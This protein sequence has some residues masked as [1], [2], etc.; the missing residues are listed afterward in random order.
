MF[1]AAVCSWIVSTSRLMNVSLPDVKLTFTCWVIPDER[2]LPVC[3]SAQPASGRKRPPPVHF[4][5]PQKAT[6]NLSPFVVT[7][8]PLCLA[9]FNEL[10]TVLCQQHNEDCPK[11]R[12][13]IPF[14]RPQKNS[15]FVFVLLSCIKAAFQSLPL[16]KCKKRGKQKKKIPKVYF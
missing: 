12:M 6:D 3:V 10:C 15:I 14:L 4:T 13:R 8:L 7:S 9:H 11:I 5:C 2:S 1:A 16:T